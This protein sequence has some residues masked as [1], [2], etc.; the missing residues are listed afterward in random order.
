MR[1]C[2][3]LG[4]PITHSLSPTLHRAAYDALGLDWAYDAHE[5]DAEGLAGFLEGMGEDWRG[6][7]LTM[8]LKQVAVGL[9]T[10]V[11][12]PARLVDA[13]NTVLVEP[14]GALVGHNTDVPGFVAAWRAAGLD[15]QLSGR[16]VRTA[17][18]LGAGATAR[19]ALAALAAVGV[20]EVAVVVRDPSRAASL[21][22][23]AQKL[24][25]DMSVSQLREDWSFP[26]AD[27][28]VSTL[29]A[30]AL[31]ELGHV[32]DRLVTRSAGVCD[33]IY[34]PR[35]TRLLQAARQYDRPISEGFDLLLHQ[36]A[37]QVELMT[38]SDA[39]PLEVM[40]EAGLAELSR[41]EANS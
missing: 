34:A 17:A 6:L 13:V 20:R 40:R 37:L 30:G 3:V 16:P 29:P 8:P 5:V 4:S 1:R 31:D 9:C 33:V 24:G 19:S 23:L 7:S 14:D 32:V 2:G 11:E 10:R 25:V 38:G 15:R 26:E 39:A 36:A 21:D 28:L 18:L 12:D 41:R 35:A 22:T 27:L